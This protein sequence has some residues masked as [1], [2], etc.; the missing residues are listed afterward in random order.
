MLRSSDGVGPGETCRTC[1][2]DCPCAGDN[3]GFEHGTLREWVANDVRGAA[4]PLAVVTAGKTPYDAFFSSQPTEGKYSL[5]TGFDGC[6]PGDITLTHYKMVTSDQ[7][8]VKFDFRLQYDLTNANQN[9]KLSVIIAQGSTAETAT[10]V[11][12][13]KGKKATMN[14]SQG[15]ASLKRFSGNV[16]ITFDWSVPE[17]FSG[18][19]WFEM[20]NVRF[21]SKDECAQGPQNF[22][23]A[24]SR[25]QFT[26]SVLVALAS[27]LVAMMLVSRR[28]GRT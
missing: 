24:A 8:C 3:F 19:A 17:C 1:D 6:G 18:P 21:P 13:P 20:D 5:V 26:L 27:C 10:I 14:W 9:R 22:E 4:Y 11:T 15:F 23:S 25:L 28:I 2:V 16:S 7:Q 12:L